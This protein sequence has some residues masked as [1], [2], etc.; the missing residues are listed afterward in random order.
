MTE[1]FEI[2]ASVSVVKKGP[3]PISKLKQVNRLCYLPGGWDAIF[4]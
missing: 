1:V 3:K 2:R 4:I